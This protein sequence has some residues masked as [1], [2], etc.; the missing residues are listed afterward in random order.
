M[1]LTESIGGGGS[2]AMRDVRT[3][4]K[5]RQKGSSG[6]AALDTSGTGVGGH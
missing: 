3:Q 1:D 2:H 6:E 5:S 4:K